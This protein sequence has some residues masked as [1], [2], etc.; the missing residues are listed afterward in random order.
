MMNTQPEFHIASLWSYNIGTWTI[1]N[2]LWLWSVKLW[3]VKC[4]IVWVVNLWW[5]ISSTMNIVSDSSRSHLKLFALWLRAI[6]Q[7]TYNVY[8]LLNK[9]WTFLIC[10]GISS[11]LLKTILITLLENNNIWLESQC[12][13]L[14]YSNYHSEYLSFKISATWCSRFVTTGCLRRASCQ[15]QAHPTL[16]LSQKM[17]KMYI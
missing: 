6:Q 1:F 14:Q 13:T 17:Q 7:T 16:K 9:E 15:S 5:E 3:P 11:H 10:Q 8:F 2:K 12:I 4:N